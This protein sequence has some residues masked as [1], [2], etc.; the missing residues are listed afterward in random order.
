MRLFGKVDFSID[1]RDRAE[2]IM[3]PFDKEL[4]VTQP[5]VISKSDALSAV[6]SKSD[7]AV[8]IM[9]KDA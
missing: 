5:A 1:R 6:S 8:G 3:P 2:W 9:I 4:R 7:A